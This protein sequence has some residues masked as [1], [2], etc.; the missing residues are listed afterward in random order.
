MNISILFSYTNCL[1]EHR[2]KSSYAVRIES[3]E[4]LTASVKYF[5]LFPAILHIECL[6]SSPFYSFL[7][8][9]AV[10]ML[11]L[12]RLK[13]LKIVTIKATYMMLRVVYLFAK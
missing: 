3:S 6:V 8:F 9:L 11:F 12:F 2:Q 13:P 4:Y 7:S 10:G 5:D 1:L